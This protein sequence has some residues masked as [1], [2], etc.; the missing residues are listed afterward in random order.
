VKEVEQPKGR[1]D[2]GTVPTFE[3]MG[4]SQLQI[5]ARELRETFLREQALRSQLEEKNQALE[6]RVRELTSLNKMFRNHL[7]VRFQAEEGYARLHKNMSEF[8][9]RL[10][11]LIAEARHSFPSQPEQGMP[12]AAPAEFEDA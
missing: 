9:D 3:E 8:L 6:Q 1:H 7:K 5:Y 11:A 2:T 4:L 12:P 10:E